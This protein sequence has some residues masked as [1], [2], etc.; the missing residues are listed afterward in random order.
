MDPGLRLGPRCL[1][2]ASGDDGNQNGLQFM[3]NVEETM[4]A[5]GMLHDAVVA[6]S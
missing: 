4:A 2:K 1:A 3:V 5:T 6:R